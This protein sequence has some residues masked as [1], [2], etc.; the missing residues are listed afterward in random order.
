MVLN[1]SSGRWSCIYKPHELLCW[2]H[3]QPGNLTRI[4]CGTYPP[5]LLSSLFRGGWRTPSVKVPGGVPGLGQPPP[6]ASCYDPQAST[7]TPDVGKWIPL[8]PPGS[9]C[10]VLVGDALM[11]SNKEQ[12]GSGFI[13]QHV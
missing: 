9:S 6:A 12:S 8:K 3:P 2:S 10:S 5:S 11:L 13:S 4:G 7:L 1:C